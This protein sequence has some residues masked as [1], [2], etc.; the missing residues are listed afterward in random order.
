[1]THQAQEVLGL[2]HGQCAEL[3]EVSQPSVA[4]WKEGKTTPRSLIRNHCI[5]VLL[6]NI[7]L[8]S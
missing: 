6:K 4:R 8:H 5:S 7:K 3:F 1:M 2:D